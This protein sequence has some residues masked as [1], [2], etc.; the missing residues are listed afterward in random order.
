MLITKKIEIDMGHRV[1]NHKSK[2]KNIHGHRYVIEAGVEG[3]II[4]QKGSNGEGMVI[5]FGDLKEIMLH[6]IDEVFD[7]SLTVYGEDEFKPL[8]EELKTRG[9]KINYVNFIPTAENL[10]KHWFELLDQKLIQRK[11]KIKFVRVW[12]TPTSTATYE[13]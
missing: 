9:Q 10:A 5:D 11:I 7:H 3:E 13:H 4:G 12:E 6:N 1:P 8:F 2:C